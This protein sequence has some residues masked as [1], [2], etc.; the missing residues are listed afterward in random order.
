[1]KQLQLD[2]RHTNFHNSRMHFIRLFS[3][4]F[5]LFLS[6]II[7]SN[8]AFVLAEEGQTCTIECMSMQSCG[9]GNAFLECCSGEFERCTSSS[10]TDYGLCLQDPTCPGAILCSSQYVDQCGDVGTNPCEDVGQRC[11][12]YPEYTSGP[13]HRDAVYMCAADSSCPEE[14][15]TEYCYPPY[16]DECG[17]DLDRDLGNPCILGER[18]ELDG[19]HPGCYPDATCPISTECT[20]ESVC[21]DDD[22]PDDGNPCLLGEMCQ[23]DR[24]MDNCS[25]SPEPTC[26]GYIE[27]S[28]SV[29][30]QCGD[31]LDR[32]DGNPCYPDEICQCD[33][34]MDNCVCTDD[35]YDIC[36]LGY[37]PCAAGDPGVGY[38]D[39]NI[40]CPEETR[41]TYSPYKGELVWQCRPHPSCDPDFKGDT[42]PHLYSGPTFTLQELINLIYGILLPIAV[43]LGVYFTIRA[44]YTI[45]TSEGDPAKKKQ[46]FEELLAA[47]TGTAFVGVA[48]T[49][50]KIILD[51]IVR[52]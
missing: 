47:L 34:G 22:D 37:I 15:P 40:N 9:I 19:A 30:S 4:Y 10:H 6:V 33:H 3:V 21:G 29:E 2:L 8:S 14:S 45:K 52:G 1:M 25:C 23:C 12:Y 26:P 46:G 51:Q 50:L 31:D 32:E 5:L 49:I 38:T 13:F 11:I 28:C 48:F 20:A 27:V 24:S 18:C 17:E 43:G 7:V 35:S 39:C 44:G 42:Y 36:G 16:D 41:C